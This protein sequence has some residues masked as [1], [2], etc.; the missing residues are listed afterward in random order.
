MKFD[1]INKTDLGF[2]KSVSKYRWADKCDLIDYE[3][4]IN[5]FCSLLKE[6]IFCVL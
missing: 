3:L 1:N 5:L 2:L 6:Q 4:N